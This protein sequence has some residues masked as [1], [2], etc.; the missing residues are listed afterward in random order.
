[1]F[2]T[3]W[4]IRAMRR[5]RI[6]FGIKRSKNLKVYLDWPWLAMKK[7]QIPSPRCKPWCPTSRCT[8]TFS[9]RSP[10]LS[11]C[12]FLGHSPTRFHQGIIIYILISIW[13]SHSHKWQHSPGWEKAVHTAAVHRAHL[14]CRGADHQHHLHSNHPHHCCHH[15][16][17]DHD[18][19]WA[20]DYHQGAGV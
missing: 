19:S 11:A 4:R 14:H 13:V 8:A 3:T 10:P 15:E 2:A 7:Y 6:R 1:M 12:P 5:F 17:Q 18:Y 16:H 20:N 9:P